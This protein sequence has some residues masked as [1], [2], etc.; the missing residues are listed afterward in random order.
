MNVTLTLCAAETNQHAHGIGIA[1]E[2]GIRNTHTHIQTHTYTNTHI[3][4]HTH[5]YT[6]I[7]LSNALANRNGVGFP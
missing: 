5:I 6:F 4:K 2:G 1:A 3:Y 7:L